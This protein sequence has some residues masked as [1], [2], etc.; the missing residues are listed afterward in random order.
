MAN[1][2]WFGILTLTF[3]AVGLP[4]LHLTGRFIFRAKQKRRWHI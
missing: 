4:L 3:L 2:N 1:C